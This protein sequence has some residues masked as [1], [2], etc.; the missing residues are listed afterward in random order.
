MIQ[1]S[2]NLLNYSKKQS[3]NEKFV[4]PSFRHIILTD[5]VSYLIG[6]IFSI[7]PLRFILRRFMPQTGQGP[8]EES[9]KDANITIYAK[10]VGYKGNEVGVC[11]YFPNDPGYVDTARIVGES[12]LCFVKD[13]NSSINVGGGMWT[14][15]SCFG[16]ILLDRICKT[17]S[18][19]EYIDM[20][21]NP[22]KKMK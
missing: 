10:G 8:S 22:N 21:T 9:L 20:K 5:L 18:E 1:R 15:A 19:F 7:T 11:L 3:Y 6:T 2:N 4:F 17:G 14:P 16:Q 12:A 13:Q